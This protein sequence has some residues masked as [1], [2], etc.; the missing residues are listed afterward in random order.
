MDVITARLEE[1]QNIENTMNSERIAVIARRKDEDHQLQTRRL[2]EDEEWN[3]QMQARDR[4]ED[5]LLLRKR[6]L[7]RLSLSWTPA[8][9]AP[10]EAPEATASR[11]GNEEHDPATLIQLNSSTRKGVKKRRAKQYK[12]N[13]GFPQANDA[14]GPLF[15]RQSDNQLVHLH[16]CVIGCNKAYFPTVTSLMKHIA[17]PRFHGFG[18]GFLKDHADAIEKC[19]RAPNTDEEFVQVPPRVTVKSKKRSPDSK[20]SVSSDNVI[21]TS[22]LVRIN[23]KGPFN[24]NIN[25]SINAFPSSDRSRSNTD[26]RLLRLKDEK[27]SVYIATNGNINE[28][29]ASNGLSSGSSTDTTAAIT[30]TETLLPE[31]GTPVPIKEEEQKAADGSLAMWIDTIPS[32]A[33]SMPAQEVDELARHQRAVTTCPERKILTSPMVRKRHASIGPDGRGISKKFC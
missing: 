9:H 20:E 12:T 5:G 19:G 4:E 11:L 28:E 6:E 13:Q 26:M 27:E 25:E 22:S 1:L 14:L 10:N 8:E 21:P 24:S 31:L 15:L 3:N 30:A 29:V 2:R 16:C 7:S 32:S 33:L 18:K 23:R 17:S